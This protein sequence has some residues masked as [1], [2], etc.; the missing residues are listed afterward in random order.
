MS[1]SQSRAEL[2]RDHRLPHE[3]R[4]TSAARS[5]A[6]GSGARGAGWAVGRPSSS[7]TSGSTTS[8]RP[9]EMRLD[10]LHPGATVERSADTIGWDVKV[11]AELATT[12]APTDDELR[13]IREE[14]DPGGAYTR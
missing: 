9:G 12:A 1:M 5:R 7:P 3:P 8:T 2:R 14:L 4:A 11:A 13:L 10:S 6:S